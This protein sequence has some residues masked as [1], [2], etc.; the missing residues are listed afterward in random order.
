[1][2]ESELKEKLTEAVASVEG[3][4]R[5][6]VVVALAGASDSYPEVSL[7]AALLAGAVMLFAVVF[8]PVVVPEGWVVVLVVLAQLAVAG[9]LRLP[10]LKRAL[11][12][13]AR[14]RL[15][16]TRA[17][18]EVFYDRGLSQTRDRSA[19]LVYVSLLEREVR[20]LP[21][22]GVL[23]GLG[24]GPFNQWEHRLAGLSPGPDLLECLAELQE[25]CEKALPRREDDED[26]IVESILEL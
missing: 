9:L 15:Q 6:E 22:V 14:A 26:E 12:A 5:V 11:L 23:A 19:L 3:R 8:S 10:L 7:A 2:T 25:L 18:A 4:S 1:M 24:R 17:A 21:D 20:W 13:P 16:V